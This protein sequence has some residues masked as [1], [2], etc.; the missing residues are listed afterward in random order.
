MTNTLDNS[1]VSNRKRRGAV[2]VLVD[3][4]RM[5]VI[6][7][8]QHVVAPG[9][10]CFPGGG[11]ERDESAELAV[12]REVAEELGVAMRPIREIWTS[13]SPWGVELT[14]WIGQLD[15]QSVC[16]PCAAEVESFEWMTAAQMAE[17]PGLLE[18]NR[19]FLEAL[20]RG[21]IDLTL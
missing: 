21:D 11:I 17:L 13:V 15:P 8:S 1:N 20:R 7:R 14:W 6:R 19:H 4:D 3:R 18:S 2:A 16:T 10:Y 9:A 5:L 12:V